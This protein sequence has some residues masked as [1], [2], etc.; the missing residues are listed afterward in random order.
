MNT[1]VNAK[2]KTMNTENEFNGDN[3]KAP[4]ELVNKPIPKYKK[5]TVLPR[6]SIDTTDNI[7]PKLDETVKDS[8]QDNKI[9]QDSE[10]V[11]YKFLNS[12]SFMDGESYILFM[13]IALYL[14][15][16]YATIIHVSCVYGVIY[17]ESAK[18]AIYISVFGVP[19]SLM[20]KIFYLL[21]IGIYTMGIVRIFR[22]IYGIENSESENFLSKSLLLGLITTQTMIILGIFIGFVIAPF[23]LYNSCILFLLLRITQIVLELLDVYR[24]KFCIVHNTPTIFEF[25]GSYEK[26]V[27]AFVYYTFDILFTLVIILFIWKLSNWIDEIYK[28]PIN[29]E[30]N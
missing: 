11:L 19:K 5:Y 15:V 10:T 7:N 12:L 23:N 21:N 3:E 2:D 26:K 25:S 17:T 18:N 16:F 9:V 13:A 22:G 4:K 8:A 6:S 27:L 1:L 24:R 28:M 20:L 29:A 14:S 30:I